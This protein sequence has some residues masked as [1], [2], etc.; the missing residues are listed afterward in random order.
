MG[1]VA[2]DFLDSDPHVEEEQRRGDPK[3]ETGHNHWLAQL[4]CKLCDDND[5][6]PH[7]SP[8][9]LAMA[10]PGFGASL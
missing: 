9:P 5:Q 10:G 6:A 1:G 7:H 4:T 3:N 2:H 8:R